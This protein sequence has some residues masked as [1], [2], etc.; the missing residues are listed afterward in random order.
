MDLNTQSLIDAREK[1]FVLIDRN[2]TVVAANRA[3]KLAYGL[4]DDEI[5]GRKC[6]ELSHRSPVPCHMKGE[7]CPHLQVMRTGESDE[8]LH[9]HFDAQGQPEHVRLKGYPVID[10]QGQL[11][12]GEEIHRLEPMQQ[13]LDAS[14]PMQGRSPAFLQVKQQ[15]CVAA[16]TDESVLI[17]GESGTGKELAAKA[18]H[19]A[20][21]RADA[22]FVVLDCTTI[23]E[24]LFESELFGHEPGA[25]TGASGR[26]VGLFEQAD[27][28]T[29]VLDEIGELT[30]PQQCKLLRALES[31]EFRRVGGNTLLQAD[32][33]V[34]AATNRNLARMV[35]DGQF[36]S[37]LYFRLSVFLVNLP[38]L[39]ERREDIGLIADHLLS[40][41]ALRPQL[42]TAQTAASL[43]S[44]RPQAGPSPAPLATMSGLARSGRSADARAADTPEAATHSRASLGGKPRLAPSCACGTPRWQ[45]TTEAVAKLTAYNFPG[46]VRELRN[47]LA[48]AAAAAAAN[49][50]GLIDATDILLPQTGHD[51]Q[52]RLPSQTQAPT[53]AARPSHIDPASS[54]TGSMHAAAR[55]NP[56]P[57]WR[58]AH[59]TGEVLTTLQRCGG[60]RGRAAQLLGISERTLY[61]KLREAGMAE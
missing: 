60:H 1:P 37:D 5:T 14:C 12:L 35:Q 46:N 22:R 28:G 11:L 59:S 3:Y 49:H 40:R 9:L 50:N 7:H 8:T 42:A 19:E 31:G 18:L 2:Y 51:M 27:G 6:H 26:R 55:T 38:P 23:P 52:S 33:R 45:L 44:L 21:S 13:G 53:S 34:V 47:V 16:Q 30:L 25:F 48:R 20:S 43:Q 24:S 29:L 58:E 10:A 61:R 15:L 54:E 57:R 4:R 17:E 32:V 36:R 56:S 39:R 41:M